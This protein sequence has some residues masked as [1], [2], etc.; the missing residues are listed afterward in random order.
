MNPEL[1]HY[2]V[3]ILTAAIGGLIAVLVAKIQNRG[4]PE[5]TMIDQLQQQLDRVEKRVEKF[6]AR[7]RVY[8]PFILKQN[9]HIELGL[10]PPAPKIP[11]VIQDY[12]DSDEDDG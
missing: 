9:R 2:I 8:I 12:L 1:L 4:R 5:H 3:P 10:G 6:E 7:D 11:K